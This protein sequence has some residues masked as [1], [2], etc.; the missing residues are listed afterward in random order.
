M[1]LILVRV[2]RKWTSPKGDS[3]PSGY[4]ATATATTQCRM[5]PMLAIS[6]V[7]NHWQDGR[8]GSALNP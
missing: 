8:Y 4:P 5:Q 3:P 7:L 2:S 6:G 1:T